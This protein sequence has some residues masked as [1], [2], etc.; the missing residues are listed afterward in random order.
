MT[1]NTTAPSFPAPPPPPPPAPGTIPTVRLNTEIPD[2]RKSGGY[3]PPAAIQN[4][5]MTKDKKPFT[6]TPGGLDLSQIRSPRMQRR[7]TRNAN[8]EGVGEHPQAAGPKTSP[9]AQPPPQGPLP[10]SAVAAMQPQMAVPVFPTGGSGSVHL[11]HVNAPPGNAPPPPPPP[12]GPTAVEPPPVIHPVS[13]TIPKTTTPVIRPVQS[14][15]PKTE[16]PKPVPTIA[17]SP[18]VSPPTQ[19][20][21]ELGSIYVPP[22]TTRAQVGSLYIPPITN[23]TQQEPVTSPQRQQTP[24]TPMSPLPTL[25]KA[26][27]PWMSQHQRQQQ[28]QQQNVPPWM[29]R[30]EQQQ[31]TAGATRIIPIQ[32]EGR[33]EPVQPPQ[34]QQA[35]HSQASNQSQTRIIPIQIEGASTTTNST[36]NKQTTVQQQRR[37]VYVHNKFNP[38]TS[39]TSPAPNNHTDSQSEHNARQYQHQQSWGPS[40]GNGG[41]IQ[42]RSFRVLQK[43]TDTD[44]TE[45][46]SELPAQEYGPPSSGGGHW[47]S[48]GVP[49]QQMHKLQLNEDD[50]ALMNKFRAQVP[51]GPGM[52]GNP[53]ARPVQQVSSGDGSPQAY[54]PPSEQQVQEP[55][56]YTGGAIPSRSFRMLQAMTAP[57][58]CGPGQSDM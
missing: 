14:P 38:P 3:E 40:G 1:E 44:N 51:R 32:V 24:Q 53:Q 45:S 55:R 48:Q 17:K 37:P 23:N 6:Y 56:K 7:I 4:A 29:H 57:E 30:E 58:N 12:P 20:Q 15:M 34:P 26:P 27:T 35:P 43:I 31:Q 49:V 16:P 54:I 33:N 50:R 25:N 21:N 8:A 36:S 2:T 11:H 47:N 22:V 52:S 42:S 41:P 28:Q 9:L 18:P 5:M 39:P 13:N 19:M 46:E 10:P